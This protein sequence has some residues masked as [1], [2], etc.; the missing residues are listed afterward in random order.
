MGVAW[1]SVKDKNIRVN[2]CYSAQ[3]VFYFKSV[4]ICVNQRLKF[5]CVSDDL[6]FIKNIWLLLKME[7]FI[8]PIRDFDGL[9]GIPISHSWNYG[10]WADFP[11]GNFLELSW[12]V[13]EFWLHILTAF[14]CSVNL[15]FFHKKSRALAFQKFVSILFAN[16]NRIWLR[17]W[18]FRQ[19]DIPIP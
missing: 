16:Q 19:I 17:G 10:L 3:S 6:D 7:N 14:V 15:E 1:L 2:Q 18:F 4:L 9:G 5:V 11:A 12:W 8:R 13:M